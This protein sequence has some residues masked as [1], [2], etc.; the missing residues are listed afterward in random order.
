MKN[1]P[2]EIVLENLFSQHSHLREGKMLDATVPA[3]SPYSLVVQIPNLANPVDSG[4]RLKEH[5]TEVLS[6]EPNFQIVWGIMITKRTT[7]QDIKDA[8]HLGAR[9]IKYI[10][11]KTSTNSSGGIGITLDELPNHYDK[12]EEGF[13]LGMASLNHIERAYTKDGK[14]IPYIFREERAIEDFDRLVRTFPREKIRAEHV[15]TRSLIDYIAT[16]PAN[17]KGGFAIQHAKKT[18]VDVFPSSGNIIYENFCM[19]VLKNEYNRQ[20]VEW[21]MAKG[22][23]KDFRYTPDDAYHPWGKKLESIP[24]CFLPPIIALP[25]LCQIFEKHGALNRLQEFAGITKG[26]EEFFGIQA[27]KKKKIIMINE[28]WRVPEIIHGTA[29][30]M[31][32]ELLSWKIKEVIE[33]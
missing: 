27:E 19:P 23:H 30:F 17:V 29:P 25:L 3:N 7:R 15:S 33:I 32:G 8:Y 24:G 20:M 6:H 1:E 21:E 28:T 31:K 22:N 26:D 4:K 10:P 12:F 14:E 16:A 2:E 9:F 13:K 11:A 18:Y 5:Q